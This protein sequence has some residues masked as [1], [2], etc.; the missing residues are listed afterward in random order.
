ME[1]MSGELPPLTSDPS[2]HAR[3][4][5]VVGVCGHHNPSMDHVLPWCSPVCHIWC[6][7]AMGWL[8]DEARGGE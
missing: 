4:V 6:E 5:S 7:D 3:P 2:S 1:V 8:V